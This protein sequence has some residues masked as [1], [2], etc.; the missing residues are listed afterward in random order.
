MDVLE[1]IN[2]LC[3]FTDS[4][5]V[6]TLRDGDPVPSNPCLQMRRDALRRRVL[7]LAARLERLATQA[8]PATENPV[9]Q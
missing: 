7:G 5:I 6:D 1:T 9:Q 3:H 8:G 4:Q 2:I